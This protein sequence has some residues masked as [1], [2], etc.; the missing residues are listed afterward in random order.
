MLFSEL[1]NIVV[2]KVSVIGFRERDRH[3]RSPL[4]PPLFSAN[5]CEARSVYKQ[6]F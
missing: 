1:Y 6:F 4:D 3:N 2:D 5:S